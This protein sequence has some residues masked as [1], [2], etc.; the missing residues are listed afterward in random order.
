LKIDRLARLCHSTEF[1]YTAAALICPNPEDV[2]QDVQDKHPRK[3]TY[4][5]WLS[6]LDKIHPASPRA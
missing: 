2:E 1:Q 6:I 3:E 5:Y 4:F